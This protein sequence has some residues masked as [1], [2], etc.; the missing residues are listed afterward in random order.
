MPDFLWNN[1]FPRSSLVWLLAVLFLDFSSAWTQGLPRNWRLFYF[2]F[3]YTWSYFYTRSKKSSKCLSRYCVLSTSKEQRKVTIWYDGKWHRFPGEG[4]FSQRMWPL[5]FDKK[6]NCLTI[7]VNQKPCLWWPRLKS[8]SHRSDSRTRIHWHLGHAICLEVLCHICFKQ[9]PGGVWLLSRW[10]CW[11]NIFYMW[12]FESIKPP[13]KALGVKE[14]REDEKK[15]NSFAVGTAKES[16]TIF[17][18]DCV[19]QVLRSFSPLLL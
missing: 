8:S 7:E 12:F 19:F 16:M 2:M 4:E 1:I 15:S 3:S 11:G 9:R 10:L 14:E 13:V 17:Y 6:E 18:L 5:V